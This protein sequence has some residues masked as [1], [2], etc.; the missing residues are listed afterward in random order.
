MGPASPVWICRLSSRMGYDS[1]SSSATDIAFP[2]KLGLH[3]W[4][5]NRSYRRCSL[6][7]KAQARMTRKETLFV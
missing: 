6:R 3:N 7:W 5:V 4:T 2:V 1:S